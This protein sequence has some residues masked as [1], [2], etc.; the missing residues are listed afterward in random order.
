MNELVKIPTVTLAISAYNEEVNIRNFLDS[1]L[2]QKEQGFLLEKILIHSDG[3]NDNTVNI[4]RSF[5]SKKVHVIE[6]TTRKGKSSRL[7]KIYENLDSDILVQSDAD[8]VMEHQFVVRDLIEPLIH[9]KEV[10]MTGGFMKPLPGNTFTEKAVNCTVEAYMPL[11]STL[12]GGNNIFSVDGRLLAYKKDL[13]KKI[14]IPESM[15]SND[16]FTYFS[17]LMLGYKYMHVPTA[18]I[19]YRSPTSIKDQLIQESRFSASYFKHLKYFPKELVRK[20]MKIPRNI[21]IKIRIKQFIKHP[22]MCTYIFLI[23][24]YCRKN[25]KRNARLITSLWNIAISTKRLSI[26]I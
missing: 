17:C 11:R 4:A 10:G 16:K 24:W 25:A 15:T 23:N 13:V 14:I 5:I 3:S 9:N 26:R 22:I 1:V 12:K 18:V 7:N 6:D 21:L 20:E 8:I 2:M 19:L